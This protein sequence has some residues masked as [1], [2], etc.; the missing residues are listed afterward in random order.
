MNIR[1]LTMRCTRTVPRPAG[2]LRRWKKLNTKNNVVKMKRSVAISFLICAC[3]LV[4]CAAHYSSIKPDSQQTASDNNRTAQ[5]IVG[6]PQKIF[7]A[8]L[9]VIEDNF[10][11]YSDRLNADTGKLLFRGKGTGAL[12]GDVEVTITLK[13][14]TGANEKGEI[15]DGYALDMTSKGV[16]FNASMFPQYAIGNI[17]EAF[18]KILTEYDLAFVSVQNPKIERLDR[19][20]SNIAGRKRAV[21]QGTGFTLGRLPL[22]VTNYHVVGEEKEVEIVFPDGHVTTGNVI[23]RDKNND[24]ATISFEDTRQEPIGFQVFPSHKVTAGQEIFVIG[25]PLEAVLGDQPGITK[26]IIS[27]TVG[28]NNDSRYFRMTAQINPGNSGGPLLDAQGRMIGIVSHTLHKINF[29][30][31]TSNIPEGTNFAIKSALLLSL[32]PD[33]ESTMNDREMIAISADKIFS[34]YSKAAVVVRS[35]KGKGK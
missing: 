24:L 33:L 9:D 14:V 20:I 23:K 7:S 8:L 31:A 16:G 28:I 1:R 3:F 29:A 12:R 5:I 22:V 18:L 17:N 4:G 19:P 27:S 2:E 34:T 10:I 21:S 6:S 15:I 30:K 35:I 32:Y 11:T 26:G 13:H 25:Y